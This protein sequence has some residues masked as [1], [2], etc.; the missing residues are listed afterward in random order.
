MDTIRDRVSPQSIPERNLSYNTNID[1]KNN[2]EA[3][4]TI[5]IAEVHLELIEIE[6]FLKKNLQLKQICHKILFQKI[7]DRAAQERNITVTDKEIQAEA[8]CQRRERK[9]EKAADTVAWLADEMMSPEDWEAGIRDRVLAKKLSHALFSKEVEKFF[10]ENKFY[11]EQVIL[12]Q[13]IVPYE[14]LAW[15]I[16][17]QIEEEEMSF[18]QAA[19]LYDIDEKRRQNCGFEG[20]INRASIK[21]NIAT[22]IFSARPREIINPFQTEQ[23]YHIVMV[24]EFI[25]PQLTPEVS[26][27]IF[28]KLFDEWLASE[29]NYLLHNAGV[30]S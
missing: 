25:A 21:P 4:H 2:A 16:F 24:E 1:L 27:D 17:Y 5:A 26:Q 12:Y 11:F 9:L 22:A 8:D 19:H 30:K 20:K 13:I 23:G 14:K 15:E 10:A 18:Y 7:I 29:L 28:N 6:H 3:I